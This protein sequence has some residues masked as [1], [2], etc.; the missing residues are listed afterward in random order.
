MYLNES[1]LKRLAQD[2]TRELNR[3]ARRVAQ[4]RQRELAGGWRAKAAHSLMA[5]AERL[6]PGASNASHR[7]LA[8]H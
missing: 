6:E 8:R 5:L 7:N 4:L 3:E 1:L 2:R